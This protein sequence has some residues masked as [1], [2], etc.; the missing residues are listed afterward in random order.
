MIIVRKENIRT[1]EISGKKFE[2]ESGLGAEFSIDLAIVLSLISLND[3]RINKILHEFKI[4]II[5]K[6]GNTLEY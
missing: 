6:N 2:F 1:V 3:P 4:N 5:D